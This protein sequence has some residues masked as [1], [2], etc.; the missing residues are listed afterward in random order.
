MS[1]KYELTSDFN[2]IF[3][4]EGHCRIMSEE[5]VID[6]AS[7]Y[8]ANVLIPEEEED[9]EPESADT[10]K[11]MQEDLDFLQNENNALSKRL[12]LANDILD[13]VSVNVREIA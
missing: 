11:Y 9:D 10:I 13:S 3:G 1:K 2:V 6:L 4:I 8:Q 5:Q 12:A 7:D